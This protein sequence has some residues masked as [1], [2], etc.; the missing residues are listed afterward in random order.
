MDGWTFRRELR[1][2]PAIADIPMVVL[3]GAEAELTADL[4][5]AAWFEKSV[6]IPQVIGAVRRLCGGR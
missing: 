2:D 4:E 5:A 6:H 1:L 3:S